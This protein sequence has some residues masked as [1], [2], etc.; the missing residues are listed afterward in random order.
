M[1]PNTYVLAH[2]SWHGAWC[3][4]RVADRLVGQGHRVFATSFTG[5]GERAHLLSPSITIDTFVADLVGLIEAEELHDVILVG[6]SFGGIPI[7]GV[8]DVA[9]GRLRHLVY[10]DGVVL[11]SGRHSFSSLPPDE[12]ES[13]IQAAAAATDGLAKPVLA[14]LPAVWGINPDG[15]DHDWVMRRLTPH[16]LQTYVTA[17]ELRHPIGNGVP[18]T[19]VECTAP[20]H[21]MLEESRVLVKSLEGW[22][23]VRLEAPHEAMITHPDEVAG[24]LAQIR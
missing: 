1:T 15:P 12:A 2:G 23:Y 7:T 16:P 11:E 19:Y 18:R 10:L 21:P 22:D 8:A 24:L 6:H 13:R 9:A 5:M 17:L 4:R 3:W 14:K 20:L